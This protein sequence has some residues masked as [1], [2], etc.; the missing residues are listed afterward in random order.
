[1]GDER[2]SCKT[3]V[4]M[5]EIGHSFYS[6]F[7]S[8]GQQTVHKNFT[9][10]SICTTASQNRDIVNPMLSDSSVLK[11]LMDLLPS[12]DKIEIFIRLI[13][14]SFLATVNNLLIYCAAVVPYV[15]I[16]YCDSKIKTTY[17]C[18]G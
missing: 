4:L 14:F 17:Y 5:F 12:L 6:E 9:V 15:I 16:Y 8:H 13:I 10:I 11:R 1:M 2:V 18:D 3:F 7:R